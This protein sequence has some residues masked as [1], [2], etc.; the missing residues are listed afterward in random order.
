MLT[1]QLT[2]DALRIIGHDMEL[3]Q[4]MGQEMAFMHDLARAGKIAQGLLVA[5]KQ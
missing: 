1:M 4:A 3:M 2:G 5:R